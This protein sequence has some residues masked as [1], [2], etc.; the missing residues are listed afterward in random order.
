MAAQENTNTAAAPPAKKSKIKILILALVL[1]LIVGGAGGGGYYFWSKSGE[2]KEE[3]AEKGKKSKDSEK[4]DETDETEETGETGEKAESSPASSS[5]SL[6]AALPEDADVNK[7]I[8]IQPFIVNLADTEQSRY[9]R[10]TVSLGVGGEEES[11][12]PDQLFLTRVRNAMLAV[13]SDKKSEEILS[14]EGKTKLRKELL[15][16]SQAAAEEPRVLAIYI[17]DFI[18]QL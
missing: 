12:K 5:K 3:T 4:T 6:Q 7:I 16:A 11:E 15:E 1:L 10:M 17:T 13:L 14:I 18:V 2:A 9:L 8:E